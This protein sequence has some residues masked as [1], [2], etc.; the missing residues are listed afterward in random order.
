MS[1]GPPRK[2]HKGGWARGDS[3][4]DMSRSI[5]TGISGFLIT[6]PPS[7][8]RLATKEALDLL[9]EF[10]E[11]LYPDISLR[12]EG[13]GGGE[14][15]GEGEDVCALLKKELETMRSRANKSAFR[16]LRD[17]CKGVVIVENTQ[18]NEIDCVHVVKSIWSAWKGG[19]KFVRILH[20]I[21]PF[22]TTSRAE[23]E[24]VTESIRSLMPLH[25]PKGPFDRP[26]RY[27]VSFKSRNN[28]TVKRVDVYDEVTQ[29]VGPL[30]VVD[31]K[32]PEHTFFVLPFKVCHA[33]YDIMT[34]HV[35]YS[36]I[37]GLVMCDDID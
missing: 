9:Y 22:Q 25:F 16:T 37:Q 5:R 30:H 7:K 24:K 20:S 32:T 21:T 17:S 34:N 14:G 11:E 31:L 2:K 18:P 19:S 26:L 27:A 33:C 6:F 3:G 12:G 29:C 28:K 1:S 13:E 8:D 36:F 15:E 23:I 4:K 10:T 35:F